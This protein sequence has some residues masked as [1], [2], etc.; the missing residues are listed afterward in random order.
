MEPDM[1]I[2]KVE[3]NG[4]PHYEPIVVHVD[5]LLIA[6]KSLLLYL[7]MIKMM[8]LPFD[9]GKENIFASFR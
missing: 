5:D 9:R 7:F 3:D 4:P 8:H 2:R 1:W 6:S